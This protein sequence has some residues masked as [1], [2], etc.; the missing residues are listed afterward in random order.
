MAVCKIDSVY[1]EYRK[2]GFFRVKLLPRLVIEGVRVELSEAALQTN[3]V[4]S[5]QFDPAPQVGRSAVEW[6]GFSLFFPQEHSPRLQAK[7]VF[8]ATIAG[9]TVYQLEDVTL[10]TGGTEL[11]VP[12]AE[13][14]AEG[15]SG[16]V[17]WSHANRS[18]QWDLLTGQCQTNSTQSNSNEKL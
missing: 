18:L 16:R 10:Q 1:T 4:E 17:V 12:K 9:A 3:W 15:S 5:L 2:I 11:H 14:R 6:R 8:P 13:L 7:H